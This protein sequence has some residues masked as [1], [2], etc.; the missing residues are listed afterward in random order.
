MRTYARHSL[1]T[2]KKHNKKGKVLTCSRGRSIM[3]ELCSGHCVRWLRV[4]HVSI[5]IRD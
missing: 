3:V 4:R 5:Q 1:T 2:K